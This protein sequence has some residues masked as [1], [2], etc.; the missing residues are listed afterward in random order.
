MCL[1]V[2]LLDCL[3]VLHAFVLRVCVYVFV[4]GCLVL[5]LCVYVVSVI[6]CLFDASLPRSYGHHV[7][8]A[9]AL[10]SVLH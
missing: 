10:Q 3:S 4:C 1:S 6:A 5:W 2:G 9:A 8:Q 7:P